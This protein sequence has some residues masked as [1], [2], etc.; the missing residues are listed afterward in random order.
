MIGKTFKPGPYKVEE[1]KGGHY[2]KIMHPKTWHNG[3]TGKA[4]THV[5]LAAVYGTKED[6]DLL[7]AAPDMYEAL[8]CILKLAS[9]PTTKG[10]LVYLDYT[11][12]REALARARGIL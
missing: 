3:I 10:E 4:E 8:E 5:T 12:A 11:E 7:A 9:S 6:A 1:V 2:Y